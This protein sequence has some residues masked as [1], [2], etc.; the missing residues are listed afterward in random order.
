MPVPPP[1][2]IFD[3]PQVIE[4]ATPIAGPY[5]LWYDPAY[6]YEGAKARFNASQQIAALK[7]SFRFYAGIFNDLK[8]PI[9]G[10]AVLT[11][12]ALWRR[13]SPNWIYLWLFIWSIA[14]LFMYA[15]DFP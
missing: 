7:R 12:L 9:T 11:V 1:R 6:W 3:N 15:L 13:S 14:I 5:P 2:T 10:L 4:F 8:Y